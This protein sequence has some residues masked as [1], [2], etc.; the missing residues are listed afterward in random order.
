MSSSLSGSGRGVIASKAS[1]C[2]WPLTLIWPCI[3]GSHALNSV[4]SARSSSIGG[5]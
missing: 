3:D 4:A 2:G 1:A 5:S